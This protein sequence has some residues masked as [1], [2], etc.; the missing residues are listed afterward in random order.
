MRIALIDGPVPLDCPSLDYQLYCCAPHTQA[1]S[2]PA[3]AHASQMVAA[4]LCGAPEV[5]IDNYVVFPG[6]LAT[7][8]AAVNQALTQVIGSNADIIHCSFG[9]ENMPENVAA[10]IN[11]LLS[12]GKHV[13]ASSAARGAVVYPA[14]FT[15][16]MSVQGD[17]R[18]A[19]GQWSWLDL[20]H[21]DFGANPRSKNPRIA[22]ASVAAAHFTG[23]LARELSEKPKDESAGSMI[24]NADYRGREQRLA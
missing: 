11:K 9:M 2:S 17:A 10:T 3:S 8:V 23:L 22:G 7:T 13:V 19:M 18:C 6:K 21:A 24:A 14:N 5:T 1:A 4:I 12:E 16:V 15:G 20:P